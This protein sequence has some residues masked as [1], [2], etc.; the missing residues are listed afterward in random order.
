[1]IALNI[2]VRRIV[3]ESRPVDDVRAFGRSPSQPAPAGPFSLDIWGQCGFISS[4]GDAI[5][6]DQLRE[7][8]PGLLQRLATL[9]PVS[10]V[11]DAAYLD[12]MSDLGAA[13]LYFYVGPVL[14][15]VE[16]RVYPESPRL[17]PL[18]GLAQTVAERARGSCC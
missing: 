8:A 17:G 2:V 12:P 13:R 3:P 7:D 6:I 4:W 9:T 10:G 15:S 14:L 18:I 16:L 11:G 5:W 1:M